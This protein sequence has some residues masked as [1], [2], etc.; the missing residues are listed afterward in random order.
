MKNLA[1]SLLFAAVTFGLAPVTA[2]AES[3]RCKN[4]TVNVGDPRSSVVQRC[5]E[6][7]A[8]DSF[9][10]PAES[11]AVQRNAAGATVVVLPCE[12]VDEWTYN[13]GYGQF[14]TTLQLEGGKVTG[15]KYGDRVK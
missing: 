9:C 10:K 15:I 1:S 2:S 8:K 7:V 11:Q 5:G 6:P 4:D 14:M 13:P 3:L 12:K